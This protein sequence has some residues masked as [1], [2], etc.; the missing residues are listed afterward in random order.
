VS[1]FKVSPIGG[2]LLNV[3]PEEDPSS[4]ILEVFPVPAFFNKVW[5]LGL[6]IVG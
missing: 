1:H 3:S 5:A 4:F 2:G 6:V